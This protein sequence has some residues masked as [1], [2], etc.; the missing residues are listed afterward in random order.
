MIRMVPV[1]KL[2]SDLF[3][4]SE[5]H[6]KN[7]QSLDLRF[8]KNKAA[9]FFFEAEGDAMFPYILEKDVLIVDRSLDPQSGSVVIASFGSEFFCRHLEY[10]ETGVILRAENFWGGEVLCQRHHLTK[11]FYLSIAI[12]FFAVVNDF[13]AQNYRID[14]WAFYQIMMDVLSLELKSL[15]N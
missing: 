15:K 10:T 9:T 3:G 5:D 4:I 6:I 13:S 1:E 2:N 11:L 8:I 14:L 12:L 7:Y